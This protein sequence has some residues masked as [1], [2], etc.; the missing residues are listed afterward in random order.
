MM[1]QIDQLG[2]IPKNLKQTFKELIEAY[3]SKEKMVERIVKQLMK[4]VD[5]EKMKEKIHEGF[6]PVM[7]LEEIMIKQGKAVIT[8]FMAMPDM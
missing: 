5:V 4:S 6:E 8:Q 2:H 1:N 3:G 7:N